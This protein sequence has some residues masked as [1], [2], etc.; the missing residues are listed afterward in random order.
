[1]P[2]RMKAL[3]PVYY[4]HDHLTEMLFFVS[5]T[6]G[7]VL[8][9]RHRTFIDTFKALSKDAQCLLIRMINRRGHIFRH[10][11]FRYAEIADARTAL[12]ELRN[13]SLVRALVEGDYA[14]FI[15]CHTKEALINGAKNAGLADIRTSWSK[16]QLIKYFRANVTFKTAH[17]HCGG[18][19]FIALGDTEPVE[20]MLY[21][22]FGRPRT[23]SRTSRCEISASSAPTRTQT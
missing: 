1:M 13:C 21:L 22:Y 19:E 14:E 4:Y 7:P 5:E 10:G 8:N 16:A 9:E 6:Y 3:L 18:G 12:K 15:L 2:T 17:D 20:F 23:I 11:E